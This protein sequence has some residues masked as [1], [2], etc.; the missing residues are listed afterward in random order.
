M[1]D[2]LAF[3]MLEQIHGQA[4][5]SESRLKFAECV[6]TYQQRLPNVFAQGAVYPLSWCLQDA[7]AEGWMEAV[8]ALGRDL[9]GS[10][11]RG[12]ETFHSSLDALKYHG[13]LP[14]LIEMM[15][16]FWPRLKENKDVFSHS[17]ARFGN[18]G[19]D[20]E[21]FQHLEQTATPDPLDPALQERIKYFVPAP[22]QEYIPEFIANLKGTS[23]RAWKVEDFEFQP[24]RKRR[25]RREDSEESEPQGPAFTNWPQLITEFVG[26]LRYQEGVPFPRGELIREDL[27]RYFLRRHAKELDPQ[28]SVFDR[29][30]GAKWKAQK[31][32][33]PIHPLCPERVTLEVHLTNMSGMF[34]Q[35]SYTLAALFQAMPAWLRF[36]ETRQL[37]DDSIRTK[38][39]EDL[40]PLHASV[41]KLMK[42]SK[43]DP[44]PARQLEEWPA[45]AA[46]GPKEQ[47]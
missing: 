39:V 41:L 16:I 32:P 1:T 5:T 25:D 29:G 8:P 45:D 13:Q 31:P 17:I 9:A 12:L 3:D 18:R 21:I 33:L 35:R 11:S 42:S 6:R 27:Y 44:T 24:P 34:S 26:Y 4:T 38:V 23:G 28:P 19:A 40:L 30:R 2:D 47:G 20:Y 7:L 14:V 15:R 43:D 36:L 10:V 46:K 37:I 22:N